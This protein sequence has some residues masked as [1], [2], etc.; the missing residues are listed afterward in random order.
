MKPIR[1]NIPPNNPT[2]AMEAL[3][4]LAD[5]GNVRVLKYQAAGDDPSQQP[6]LVELADA[7]ARFHRDTIHEVVTD[8]AGRFTRSGPTDRRQGMSYGEEHQ[9]EASLEDQAIR[10]VAKH[11]DAIVVR[12]GLPSWRLVAPSSILRPLQEMLS[13]PARESLA[14]TEGA[15][16][17]AFPLAELEQR[18][19]A[20]T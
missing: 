6:H 5:L 15:D 20:G 2:H 17:V 9:L 11:L 13:S 14:R 3:I 10:R 18:C 16:L 1:A 19:L 12:E 7:A 8:Q 4:I